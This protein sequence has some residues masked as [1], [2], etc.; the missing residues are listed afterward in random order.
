[1]KTCTGDDGDGSTR[2][3]PG[4][5]VSVVLFRL[6]SGHLQVL[7]AHDGFGSLPTDAPRADESLDIAAHRIVNL[8]PGASEDYMEQL[9]T[10][11]PANAPR[12]NVVVS[13]LALQQPAELGQID[14]YGN[15]HQV[16]DVAISNAADRSVLDYALVR[17]R[18]KLGY[19]NIAFNLVPQ[20][21]TIP[22]LQRAYEGILLHHLDKRNF[23]RRILASGIL[24]QTDEKRRDGNHRPAAL[25]RFAS[26]ADHANYLTPTNI[27]TAPV[28]DQETSR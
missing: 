10:F 23:R 8:Q 1:M 3:A 13:Y 15:W 18:A 2:D 20:K 26:Q 4:L 21:F 28:A 25:Y 14:E 12:R 7:V 27:D 22:E 6:Q 24:A 16:S 19:T 9:Y 11:S 17:L 5:I